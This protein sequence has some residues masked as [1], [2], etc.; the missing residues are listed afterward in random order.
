MFITQ[1][2]NSPQLTRVDLI[3]DSKVCLYYA[4]EW[5]LLRISSGL[6]LRGHL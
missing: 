1:K 3:I 5:D 4:Y 6:Q 2:V